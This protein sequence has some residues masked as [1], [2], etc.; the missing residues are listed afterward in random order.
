MPTTKNTTKNKDDHARRRTLG[1]ATDSRTASTN[2]MDREGPTPGPWEAVP[3]ANRMGD[4]W[5]V[6]CAG[7][8]VGMSIAQMVWKRDAS[9]IA[10]APDLLAALKA[11]VLHDEA[12]VHIGD[13]ECPEYVS[14]QAAIAKAEGR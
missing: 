10:A 1:N 4:S 8:T 9:L 12:A 7:E 6:R 3:S 13:G 11:F 2:E 14:A 5:G